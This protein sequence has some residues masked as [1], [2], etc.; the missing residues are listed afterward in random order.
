V[1]V[2][3]VVGTLAMFAPIQVGWFWVGAR[4]FDA[5]HSIMLDGIV[6]LGGFLATAIAIMKVLTRLDAVWLSLRRR[7]GHDR[8]EGALTQ[9][10]VASATFGAVAF[11]VWFHIL[12]NAYII[13][14]MPTE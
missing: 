6:V 4:V 14:F 12:E 3:E 11:W 10:V 8:R 5:T 1:L 2:L 7:A 9:V 13:P